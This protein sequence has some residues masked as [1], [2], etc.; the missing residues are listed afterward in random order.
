MEKIFLAKSLAKIFFIIKTENGYLRPFARILSSS[1][2]LFN[3]SNY[4]A[5][6]H[7]VTRP[8]C[9]HEFANILNITHPLGKLPFI[10]CTFC[11]SGNHY[12]KSK[13]TIDLGLKLEIVNHLT[14]EL[15]RGVKMTCFTW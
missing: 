2:I 1:K 15:P 14:L 13:I 6:R 8:D 11:H 4:I 3:N 5:H 9:S 12:T 10:S 7:E